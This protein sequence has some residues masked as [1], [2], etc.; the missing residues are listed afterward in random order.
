MHGRPISVSRKFLTPARIGLVG[1]DGEARG[2][3]EILRHRTPEIPQRLDGGVLLALDE[4]LGI[5]AEQFAELA[6]EFGGRVQADR[7]LQIRPLQRLAQHPAEFAVHADID[8]GVD[9]LWDIREVAAERKHH[10]DFGADA[11]DQPANFGEIGRHVEGAVDRPDDIDPR[12]D[13]VGARLALRD[14]LDAVFFPE[15][16]DGAVGALPLVLVDGARQEALDIGSLRRDA[17]A[18][19]LG[20]RAGDHDRRQIR[21]E[22]AMRALHRAFGAGL[23]E[24]FLAETR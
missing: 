22:H 5:D 4:R 21:I 23:A 12:L 10:V 11:L 9:E 6:Q 16:D 8:V 18:D 15:P 7:R 2:A 3:E 1:D 14:F 13:A 17:A 19:H 20:D 24:F